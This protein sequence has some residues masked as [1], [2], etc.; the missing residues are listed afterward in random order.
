MKNDTELPACPISGAA[1]TPVFTATILQKHT[2]QYFHC[3]VSGLLKTEAPHWLQEAYSSA[4]SST[5]TGLVKR[6]IDTARALE[7][8][9]DR[10]KLANGKILDMAGGFGLLTRLLRDAGFDAYTTDPYCKNNHAVGFEPVD[11]FG[12]D[13]L[14]AFEVLE[15]LEDPVQF[16]S[17]AFARYHCR[18]LIFSTVTYGPEIPPMDWWYYAFE[19][20][21]HISFYQPRTLDML[22]TRLGCQYVRL[23][24]GLHLFTDQKITKYFQVSERNGALARLHA[25]AMRRGHSRR[26]RTVEDHLEMKRKLESE[27][28]V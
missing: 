15:H 19:T 16:L 5:D 4:I 17:D 3:P 25:L 28:A 9:I 12:A 8:L 1:L 20:G 2:V 13:L 27:R 10:L 23:R 26:S 7:L 11:G 14:L 22:A 21:Q 18:T 6:N 24:S